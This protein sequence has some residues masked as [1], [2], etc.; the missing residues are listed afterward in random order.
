MKETT[1]AT[2]RVVSK[3][4]GKEDG[5]RSN[6]PRPLHKFLHTV[7]RVDDFPDYVIHLY[8]HRLILKLLYHTEKKSN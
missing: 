3:L 2:S 6:H 1:I 7:L 4:T 8:I 5:R